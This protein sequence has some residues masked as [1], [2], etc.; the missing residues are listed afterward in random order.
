MKIICLDVGEKRIGVARADSSVKI[1]VPVGMVEVDGNEF[2]RIAKMS[3]VFGTE[4]FV[5][6]LPRSNEGNETAQS[7]YVRNFV[8]KLKQAIPNVKIRFQD[9]SLTSV[10]A[11][12]NLRHRKKSINKKAGDIDTEAAT[13]ILQDFL[14]SFSANKDTSSSTQ[15][16]NLK[17]DATKKK[18]K[19][20]TAA[21]VILTVLTLFFLA[22]FCACFWYR[23]ATKPVLAISCEQEKKDEACKSI[24][25]VIGEGE[26]VSVIA[27]NLFSKDLIKSPLAFKIY[28]KINNVGSDLKAGTYKLNKSLYV[29]DI[30]KIF[31]E[32]TTN[33]VVFRLTTIPGETLKEV[34]SRL[35][36]AGYTEAEVDSALSKNYD[37]PV[38][39]GKPEDKNLEGYLYGE[40][41]EFYQS[42]SVETIVTRMLDELYQ[43]VESNNLKE[44]FEK[45]GLSLY[46]G[47]ILASI[48]QKEAGNLSI[49]ELKNV[50][51]VFYNRMELGMTLGSDVTV[52]YALDQLSDDERSSYRDNA[53]KL[54]INSCYNTR[55]NAGLPCGPISNPGENALIATANPSETSYLYFLTGDDGMM[56]YSTT[57]SGHLQN[58][59]AHC[60]E[61]C[62]AEL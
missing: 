9:E 19:N 34:K 59:R 58:I 22:V 52:T 6:G 47:I 42:D 51:S 14:E 48:V 60:R 33:A 27:D 20:N 50:A 61:L 13:I 30:V 7:K 16:T 46:Q 24:D 2:L 43:V 45:Q 4:F 12:E 44:K 41:Y 49:D 25:F 31:I 26:S 62:N 23:I 3:R 17:N 11:K 28:T 8:E 55:K 56:Y 15:P 18:T 57:D 35:Q 38:L 5:I 29:E 40:T 10:Q 39:E 36:D 53:S 32:G 54:E 21:I 37:H 1:A